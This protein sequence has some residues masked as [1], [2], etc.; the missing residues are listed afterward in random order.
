MLRLKL[1]LLSIICSVAVWG[2]TIPKGTF[3][4]DNSKTRYEQ[5][6]FVY[7]SEY[8]AQTWVVSMTHES[9]DKWS[10]TFDQSIENMYRYTFAETTLPDGKIDDTFP[11]VKE[12]ISKVRNE[13]RTATTS[14]TIIVGGTFTPSSGD[15]W[16][17]GEWVIDTN[18]KGYSETLPVLFI[19]TANSQQITSKE[20]YIDATYYLETF[21]LEGYEAFGSATDQLPLE[22]RGRGNYTWR[23]FD[24]KPYRIK[25]GSKAA[26]LGMKK[27]KHFALLAHA[28]DNLGFYRNTM[29]FEMSRRLG[30][31]YTP[32]QEPVEVVLNGNYI[33]L[34]FLTETIRVDEDRVDIVEQEDYAT[35][36]SEITGGWLVEIDNYEETE[37][38]RI[39]EGNGVTM[40][41]TYKT[42]ELL[43]DAQRT[44][45]RDQ[46]NAIDDAIY[47]SDKSSTDWEE[48]VDIDHLVRFYVTQEIMQNAESF[49]GSCY[50]YRDRGEDEKWHFGPVWD[51]GNSFHNGENRFIYV[52]SPFGNHWIEEF[53]K[54]PRFQE[55]VKMVWNE[56]YRNQ[57]ASIDTFMTE[58]AD[59]IA[60]A[61]T[62][63][64]A[65]WP[66][67]G[68]SD[69]YAKKKEMKRFLDDRIK[70]LH[71][72]WVD[73]S[74]IGV[75]ASEFRVY[76]VDGG[77]IAP[78]GA[79][80]YNL[81]GGKVSAD[82]L[83]A[84]IYIVRVEDK[85]FKVLVR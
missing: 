59:K 12:N 9:G 6:K 14:A 20:D 78:Q 71:G 49:H 28:D 73:N 10:I 29:G 4:F 41:F 83:S 62:C 48:L 24:K 69:I 64:Y 68:A 27:S 23:D 7:G 32:S 40:R 22:I 54:F 85:V 43:S 18:G 3:Y 35:D 8:D 34:Y 65:R 19:N 47:V 53:A 13:M 81:S 39:T 11:N 51:F 45:L 5:V 80:I 79:E 82:N 61:A 67:Y 26:L 2:V 75:D 42:P 33:G 57:I 52:N 38:V 66:Q 1:S 50:L 25:L 46:M 74:V 58:F 16:A 15:N 37:Q 63:D 77:I 72:H 30:L 70:W 17:Q 56:F 36:A 44:Y 21:G 76:G 84:G 55:H 31:P 60:T